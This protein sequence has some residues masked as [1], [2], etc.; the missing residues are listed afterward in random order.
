[1]KIVEEGRY[2]FMK[3]G[4][5]SPWEMEGLFHVKDTPTLNVANSM[6]FVYMSKECCLA[7]NAIA[8]LLFDLLFE[9]LFE[10]FTHLLQPSIE[11]FGKLG[12]H[13]TMDIRIR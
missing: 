12:L 7:G 5:V 11:V 3:G 6:Y 1:M 4:F 2:D 9:L 10:L 13:T 8:D